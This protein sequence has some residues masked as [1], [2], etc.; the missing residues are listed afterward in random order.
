M[1]LQETGSSCG[2][3]DGWGQPH[4]AGEA[5]LERPDPGEGAWPHDEHSTPLAA[6]GGRRA[7]ALSKGNAG[8]REWG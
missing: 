1:L 2:E 7:G 4:D 6:D 5:E 3:G 8:S